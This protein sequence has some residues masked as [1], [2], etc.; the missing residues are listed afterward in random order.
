MSQSKEDNF[1]KLVKKAR[2]CGLLFRTGGFQLKDVRKFLDKGGDP[3]AKT[4]NGWSLLHLLAED[5]ADRETIRLAI[6][7]GAEINARDSSGQTP[8]HL[9]VD[10]DCDSSSRDCR[11]ASELP[12]AQVL[13]EFG[14][15]ETAR[16]D[17]GETPRDYAAAYGNHELG[18]YDSI[19][20]R[21]DFPKSK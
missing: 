17:K 8:L 6:S 7:R 18:L 13:I 15:D 4:D 5:C 12:T 19:S 11:R 10:A 3:N 1:A 16:S 14:A 2:S 20:C 9:A 21:K